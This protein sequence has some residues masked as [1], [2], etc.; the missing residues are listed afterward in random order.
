MGLKVSLND[1]RLT[2]M[3]LQLFL[4]KAANI[5]NCRHISVTKTVPADESYSIL[6]PN[7]LILGRSS[8]KPAED[9]GKMDES[10]KSQR[11]QLIQDV[12]DHYWRRWAMEVTPLQVKRQHWHQS[13]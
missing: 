8:G 12:T 10:S 6:T 4:Y 11:A 1:I 13:K 9:Y 7:D 2:S 5:T 3:K